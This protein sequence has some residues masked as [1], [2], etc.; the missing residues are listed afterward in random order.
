MRFCAVGLAGFAVDALVLLFAMK[1]LGMGPITGR[2]ISIAA[3][4]VSTWLLNRVFTFRI[5]SPIRVDELIR[6]ASAKGVGLVANLARSSLMV[7]MG[8]TD[9]YP[10]F[11]LIVASSASMAINYT[12]VKCFVFR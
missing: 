7:W 1:K 5:S 12:L 8:S 6:Y 9:S 2:C 3:A 10:L 11:A 4:M